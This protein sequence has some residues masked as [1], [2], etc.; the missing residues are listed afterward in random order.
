[1]PNLR[2]DL[3]KSGRGFTCPNSQHGPNWAHR[4]DNEHLYHWSVKGYF[5]SL[6][7][8]LKTIRT[9]N[10]A[11]SLYIWQGWVQKKLMKLGQ[12]EVNAWELG[13]PQANV[14]GEPVFSVMVADWFCEKSG[15][16]GEVEDVKLALFIKKNGFQPATI[17]KRR[18]L[19]PDELW[20]RRISSGLIHLA[21]DIIQF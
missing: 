15:W 2:A 12:V 5:S 16:I 8:P 17:L 20:N 11:S 19:H 6:N 9:W 7:F 14:R 3:K 4:L 21:L 18:V 1:M 13:W 10:W